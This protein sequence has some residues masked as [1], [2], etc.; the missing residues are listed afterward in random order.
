MTPNQI[1]VLPALVEH[2]D[3]LPE[4]ERDDAIWQAVQESEA[5]HW[6]GKPGRVLVE[7]HG[8]VAVAATDEDAAR[9]WYRTARCARRVVE[10]RSAA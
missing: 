2:L 7:L 4:N 9:E 8:V 1:D 10:R 3:Q 6:T 5:G